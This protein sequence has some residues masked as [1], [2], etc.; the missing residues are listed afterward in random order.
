MGEQ[1]NGQVVGAA[2]EVDAFALTG[3]GNLPF[4]IYEYRAGSISTRLPPMQ[5]PK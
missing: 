3:P 5:G 4:T 2:S 1:N